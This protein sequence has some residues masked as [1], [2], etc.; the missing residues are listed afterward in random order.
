MSTHKYPTWDRNRSA[1]LKV[2]FIVAL[3]SVI[4]AFQSESMATAP[5]EY[6]VEPELI[7]LTEPIRTPRDKKKKTPP[8]KAPEPE[9]ITEK[10]DTQDEFIEPDPEPI[11]KTDNEIVKN[12]TEEY[13]PAIDTANTKKF[14]P[15]PTPEP[16]FEPEPEDKIVIRAERMPCFESCSNNATEEDRRTCTEEALLSFIYSNVKYPL[17]AKENGIEGPVVIRFVIDKE[18]IIS[19]TQILKDIGG[20]CGNEVVRVIK[21]LPQW[22]PGKQNGRPVR[23]QYTMPI[24]FHL[25]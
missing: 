1:F 24:K 15:P 20:G 12:T 8:P 3:L 11:E 17:A 25:D 21:E 13:F 19:E 14:T 18:G 16:E 4:I 6:I 22:L 23:V 9:D 10:I 7:P 2:G 5:E